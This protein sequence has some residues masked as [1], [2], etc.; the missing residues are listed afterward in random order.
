MGAILACSARPRTR[1]KPGGRIAR[2]GS[3]RIAARRNVKS[4]QRLS[5]TRIMQFQMGI[6]RWGS[7][8]GIGRLRAGWRCGGD[9][10]FEY[11]R[12]DQACCASS[13]C[14]TGTARPPTAL[15]GIRRVR[16]AR[17]STGGSGASWRGG[18][19]AAPQSRGNFSWSATGRPKPPAISILQ[20]ASSLPDGPAFYDALRNAALAI[21][22]AVAR[23][24]RCSTH[25]RHCNR[26]R[27]CAR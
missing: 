22:S 1:L 9:D 24:Q 11:R 3:R 6:A 16:G 26:D 14:T 17:P 8:L 27:R 5:A 19:G 10:R 18:C 12:S 23:L 7:R 21:A 20:P 15:R 13:T 25:A 2:S 4:P